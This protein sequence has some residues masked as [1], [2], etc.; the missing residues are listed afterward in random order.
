MSRLNFS[1]SY[2]HY[3]SD[4][5]LNKFQRFAIN[6][7][8]SYVYIFDSINT[9]LKDKVEHF[10]CCNSVKTVMLPVLLQPSKG[11][12]IILVSVPEY[13]SLLK[14]G[15]LKNIPFLASLSGKGKLGFGSKLTGVAHE[16]PGI[17]V[18]AWI[19]AQ[20]GHPG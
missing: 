16:T 7:S 12:I 20:D 5:G 14:S 11:L 8:S 15:K 4:V 9:M 13:E 19:M 17:L 1:C 6:P 18:S 2:I 10:L 3:P